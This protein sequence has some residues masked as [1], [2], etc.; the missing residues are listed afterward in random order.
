M[1]K[2]LA[3]A[4]LLDGD[5]ELWQTVADAITEARQKA[6]RHPEDR[7]SGEVLDDVITALRAQASVA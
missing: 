7:D 5:D 1:N 3:L 6:P 4:D 2:L